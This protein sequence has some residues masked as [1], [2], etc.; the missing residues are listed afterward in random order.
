VRRS[1]AVDAFVP[2]TSLIKLALH[3]RQIVAQLDS[4][5]RPRRRAMIRILAQVDLLAVR[6]L[7]PPRRGW[8]IGSQLD[9]AVLEK[10]DQERYFGLG[11][12]DRDTQVHVM[13]ANHVGK[14]TPKAG[15]EVDPE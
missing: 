2:V 5:V 14:S 13:E 7:E 6:A 15:Q 12:T 3:C 1:F 10:V 4:N 8:V 9:A 11:S